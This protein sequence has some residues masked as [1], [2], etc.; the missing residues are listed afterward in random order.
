MWILWTKTGRFRKASLL[1]TVMFPVHVP[2]ALTAGESIPLVV[3][4]YRF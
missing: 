2:L 4:A 3:A 1:I